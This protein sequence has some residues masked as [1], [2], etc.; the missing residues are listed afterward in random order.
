MAGE[1]KFFFTEYK[2]VIQL[3]GLK[4]ENEMNNSLKYVI[5]D[6]IDYLFSE[7]S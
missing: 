6:S 3:K 5:T 4:R 2:I 1:L 7:F